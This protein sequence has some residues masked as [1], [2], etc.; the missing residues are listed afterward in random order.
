MRYYE[1]LIIDKSVDIEISDIKNL[2]LQGIAIY[3]MYMICTSP[4]GKGLMEIISCNDILKEINNKKDYGIIAIAM[5]E[6]NINNILCDIL[7]DWIKEG[8]DL[9]FI[10][11]YYNKRCY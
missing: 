4:L 1:N 3:N 2:I 7:G 10:K 8:K 5:G 11:N 9:N 6:K